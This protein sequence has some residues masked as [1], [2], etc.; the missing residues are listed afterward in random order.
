MIECYVSCPNAI[1][2]EVPTDLHPIGLTG[3]D[4][5]RDGVLASICLC[6]DEKMVGSVSVQHDGFVTVN[7][8]SISTSSRDCV[9]RREVV[10]RTLLLECEREY[11]FPPHQRQ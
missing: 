4:K 1:L 11:F 3:N 8:P 7:V 10:A 9:D 6:R 2:R 5:Q